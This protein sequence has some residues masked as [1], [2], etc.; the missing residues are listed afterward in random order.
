MNLQAE[1]AEFGQHKSGLPYPL[2]SW[3]INLIL[4]G[5]LVAIVL[6]VFFWQLSRV[7]ISFRGQALSYSRMVAGIIEENLQN[8]L[9]SGQVIDETVRIFLNNSGKFVHYLESI[10]PF[11]VD[12][13]AS[14]AKESGLAGITVVSPSGIVSG[15]QGWLPFTPDCN[16]TPNQVNY[17]YKSGLATLM[18]SKD[19]QSDADGSCLI[20]GLDVQR[21][22]TLRQKT[23][24]ES[25][26]TTLS[27]LPGISYV[28]IEQEG[29]AAD[30]VI[31]PEGDNTSPVAQTSL[32]T[33]A[34][35]LIVGLDA[36]Q[37][38][39]RVAE[40]QK[41]F[42]LFGVLLLI[43][44]MTSSWLMYRYQKEDLQRT[45]DFERLMARQHEEA[46]MGRATA[47]IAHEIRN[48][49]NAINI[50]L[51]RLV[52]ESYNL[53]GEQ[54]QL[55]YSMRESVKRTENIITRL[56]RFTRPLQLDLQ[57]VNL[58][59]LLVQTLKVYG[60]LCKQQS[61]EVKSKIDPVTTITG[62]KDLVG[63]L[64]ENLIKNA[65][66]A[67]PDSGFISVNLSK[68]GNRA[69][70]V[71]SN[72]GFALAEDEITKMSEPYFTTKT[73]G[74]GLGLALAQRIVQVHSGELKIR[75]QQERGIITVEVRL[76]LYQ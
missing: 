40:L 8:S 2:L 67:Q 41:Q 38:L 27:S 29:T 39:T 70:L 26:L 9:M 60:G 59:K 20:V 19:A 35:F 49:L 72:G 22:K 57:P 42:V 30:P 56:Q 46:A 23:G 13:L 68:D 47:T 65:I 16:Q 66:E 14:F 6:A 33:Q 51:Q 18:Y 54:E 71:I 69:L 12:E 53:S 34:G 15:P 32:Q 44:G 10:E 31:L 37:Y 7:K 3:K 45:R 17:S 4:F 64:L 76:P 52:M 43:L 62:D 25:I 21:V 55:L 5:L 50:G 58:D 11:T 75:N 63:E 28:R 73:R 1:Q 61:I 36:N 74:T 24:L 48:P